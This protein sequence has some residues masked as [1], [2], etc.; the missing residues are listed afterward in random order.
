MS[1]FPVSV[2]WGYKSSTYLAVMRYLC[3]NIYEVLR[4]DLALRKYYES[5]IIMMV[6][7]NNYKTCNV[8]E[9]TKFLFPAI[10]T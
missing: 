9:D 8:C 4:T 1:H 6:M 10:A 3:I 2:K 5:F 7:L